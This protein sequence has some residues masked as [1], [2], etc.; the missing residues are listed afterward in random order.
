VQTQV[1]DVKVTYHRG[2][3]T[4][5][6]TA[7]GATIQ[8]VSADTKSATVLFDQSPASGKASVTVRETTMGGITSEPL[9]TQVTIEP[10]CV[11]SINLFTGAFLCNEAGYGEYP[12][13]LTADPAVQNR[14]LNDNFWDYA[15]EGEVI[16]YD[17]SGDLNQIVTVPSQS[18]TFGD[19]TVGSVE[20]S[21]VYDSCNR[22]MTVSYSVE[23]GGD[24]YD[25]DHV[26]SVAP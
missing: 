11:L 10:F 15:A 24:V 12:V 6:W 25:T 19:G 2:G 26:F 3:S 7:E 21:G 22:T 18:F 23:Y 16:Y 1:A 8:S 17:L 4:W 13:N 9:T 20:G 5:S 14:I